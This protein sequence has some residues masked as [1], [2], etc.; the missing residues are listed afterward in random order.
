MKKT[1]NGL[2]YCNWDKEEWVS[3]DGKVLPEVSKTNYIPTKSQSFKHFLFNKLNWLGL[4]WLANFMVYLERGK[5][6]APEFKKTC[7]GACQPTPLRIPN[8]KYI[9]KVEEDVDK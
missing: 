6:K 8:P 5:R 2:G 7:C 9:S 1:K 4:T 3:W